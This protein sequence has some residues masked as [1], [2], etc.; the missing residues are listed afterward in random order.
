MWKSHLAV[1][2]TQNEHRTNCHQSSP[3][4]EIRD[5]VRFAHDV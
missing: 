1:Y 2:E 5:G 4:A 3:T